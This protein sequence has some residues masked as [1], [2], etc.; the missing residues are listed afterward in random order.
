MAIKMEYDSCLF[1]G[2]LDAAIVEYTDLKQRIKEQEEEK[3]QYYDKLEDE[4]RDKEVD[5]DTTIIE[6]R[7][8]EEIKPRPFDT[9]KV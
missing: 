1:I 3:K 9:F 5:G 6:E 7:R 8:W 2:A 4:R